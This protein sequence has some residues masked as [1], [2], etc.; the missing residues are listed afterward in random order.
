MSTIE[1][2]SISQPTYE[3]GVTGNDSL[4]T[5]EDDMFVEPSEE[6]LEE[7]AKISRVANIV[8]PV[9][10]IILLVLGIITNVL[11]VY[12]TVVTNRTA[13]HPIHSIFVLNLAVSDVMFLLVSGPYWITITSSSMWR[14]GAF[15]CPVI[16]FICNCSMA[17][18]IYTICALAWMRFMALVM[19]FRFRRSCISTRKAGYFVILAIWIAGIILSIPN[20]VYYGLYDMQGGAYSCEWTR[21]SEKAHNVYGAAKLVA[22]YLF[23]LLLVTVFYAVIGREVL[24]FMMHHNSR[25]HRG[26]TEEQKECVKSTIVVLSLILAFLICWLPHLL[27]TVFSMTGFW[28]GY[29]YAKQRFF[30]ESLGKCMSYAHAF[31]NPFIYTFASPVF[32][33][34]LRNSLCQKISQ[35]RE[36]G[37]VCGRSIVRRKNTDR[38]MLRI[39]LDTEY[40]DQTMR[41]INVRNSTPGVVSPKTEHA[42]IA[43]GFDCHSITRVT[44]VTRFASPDPCSERRFTQTTLNAVDE[45]AEAQHDLLA[46]V[47]Q[48]TPDENG[49]CTNLNGQWS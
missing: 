10:I 37:H 46:N 22:T 21:E 47:E 35:C 9:V 12:V 40:E 36:E 45:T 5:A 29:N 18:S 1:T 42:P 39:P 49:H 28:A 30:L 4:T 23:P 48:N 7:L 16:P 27:E 31:I 2:V 38:R 15:L 33:R 19:P 3:P 17:V 34:S 43:T 44:D 24:C 25:I 14:F 32:R 26:P 11:V 20:L 13:K 8:I 6:Y 41:R